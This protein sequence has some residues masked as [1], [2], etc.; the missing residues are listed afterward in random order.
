ME[1]L[2]VS[3]EYRPGI[4]KLINLNDEAVDELLDALKCAS[5][6]LYTSDLVFSVAS[7]VKSIEIKDLTEIIRFLLSLS[8]Q[9]DHSEDSIEE[10][11]SGISLSIA[12]DEEFSS[13]SD[14][15]KKRFDKQLTN[16]LEVDSVLNVT[17]K[18]VRVVRDHERVFTNSLIL[19]EIRP[20]FKPNPNE[21]IAAAAI[22]HMMK[23]EYRDIEGMK[24][25][26]VALDQLDIFQLLEQ[27]ER[28][29]LKAEAIK[30]MLKK[31]EVPFLDMLGDL[32]EGDE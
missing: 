20:V 16:F 7:Y 24:E 28:A 27:L 19:T 31:T 14:E 32:E 23:I 3:E 17:S 13:F 1:N 6:S 29:N 25:F 21:G 15:E 30:A 11:V 12:D 22:V 8:S 4:K 2:R 9:I 26:F 10:I 18:A 5:P